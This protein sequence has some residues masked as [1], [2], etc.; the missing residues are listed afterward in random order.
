MLRALY[1]NKSS[2]LQTWERLE[3]KMPCSVVVKADTFKTRRKWD[4]W[5]HYSLADGTTEDARFYVTPRTA[6]YG[7]RI[8]QNGVA[9]QAG[10]TNC[11]PLV[12][13]LLFSTNKGG[14]YS[15]VL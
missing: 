10:N 15:R 14:R 2:S 5:C 12:D 7:R 3:S 1:A 9:A 8:V 4:D 13:A 11:R 6:A